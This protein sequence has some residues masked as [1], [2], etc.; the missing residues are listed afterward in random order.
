MIKKIWRNVV[1]KK[2]NSTIIL[3]ISTLYFY[4]NSIFSQTYKT[5]KTAGGIA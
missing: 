4:S 2:N 1:M 5:D 3:F